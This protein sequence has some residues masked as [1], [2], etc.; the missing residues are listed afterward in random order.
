MRRLFWIFALGLVSLTV[1]AQSTSKAEPWAR[2]KAHDADSTA[3]IDNSAYDAFLKK[4]VVVHDDGPNG[5]RYA[6]VSDTDRNKLEQYIKRLEKTDIDHYNRRVQ[7]AY[8]LNLYNAETIDQVLE[9]YPIDSIRDA[10]GMLQQG[11]W[12][13]QVLEVEGEQLSLNDIARRIL[14]PLWHDGLSLYGVSCGALSCPSLRQT[15]YTGSNVSD[16]LYE[17]A[18]DYVNSPEGAHFD[19]DH[20]TVSKMYDWFADDFGGDTHGIINHI[21][22][23]ATPSLSLHLEATHQIDDYAF[24]WSLNSEDNVARKNKSD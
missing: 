11:P 21:R 14:R 3:T 6:D 4:Y 20:L 13:K 16:A 5:V 12:H 22:R 17:N 9:N 7:R 15:A 10:G 18:E 23:Y 1:H 8:W 24:D 19:D 2:W